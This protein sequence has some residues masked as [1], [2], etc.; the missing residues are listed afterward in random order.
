MSPELLQALLGAGGVAFLGALFAGIKQ[1]RESF[2]TSRNQAMKDLERW[3]RNALAEAEY[4]RQVSGLWSAYAG[5]CVFAMKREGMDP[6][7]MPDL[8]SPPVLEDADHHD[9]P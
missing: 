1:L 4:Y 5:T 7:P 3:R 8:P 9:H 6:P 2:G